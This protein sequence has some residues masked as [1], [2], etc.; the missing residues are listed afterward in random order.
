MDRRGP[1]WAGRACRDA[2]GSP[3]ASIIV[4]RVGSSADTG[5]GDT[6]RHTRA[7][8]HVDDVAHD[9][10]DGE[11]ARARGELAITYRDLGMFLF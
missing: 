3:R 11:L 9:D 7:H 10:V 8:V 1:G 5:R 4:G 6:H 2:A